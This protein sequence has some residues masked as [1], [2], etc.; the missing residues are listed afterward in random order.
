[1][2][3]QALNLTNTDWREAQFA[4]TSCFRRE[5]GRASGCFAQPGKQTTGRL[6]P[7][8]GRRVDPGDD[9]HFT[10]GNPFGIYAGLKLYF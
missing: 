5:V 2:S 4:D 6:D 10:P 9:V 8:T 1:V 7:L 3:F